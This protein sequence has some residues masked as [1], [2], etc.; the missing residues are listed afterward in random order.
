LPAE[1]QQ[2]F[3]KI[4]AKQA[5]RMML[6][7][8][9]GGHDCHAFRRRGVGLEGSGSARTSAGFLRRPMEGCGTA[10]RPFLSS[11]G[12]AARPG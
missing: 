7:A 8:A 10:G 9:S 4:F 11:P 3:L 1:P 6:I 5:E 2:Q 12:S